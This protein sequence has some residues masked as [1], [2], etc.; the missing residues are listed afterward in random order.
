[1]LLIIFSSEKSL[2][3]H[4][5]VKFWIAKAS[6]ILKIPY[7]FSNADVSIKFAKFQCF[8]CF[9]TQRH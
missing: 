3:C 9:L 7:F 8:V 1:M 4:K 6:K 5:I 2:L